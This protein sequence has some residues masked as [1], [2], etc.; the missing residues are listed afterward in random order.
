MSDLPRRPRT[1]DQW[2]L[3][4]FGAGLVCGLIVG[5]FIGIAMRRL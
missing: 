3:L 4:F 5:F 2:P 1:P